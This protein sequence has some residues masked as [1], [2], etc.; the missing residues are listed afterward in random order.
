MEILIDGGS[1]VHDQKCG[2]RRKNEGVLWKK[3]SMINGEGTKVLFA[4]FGFSGR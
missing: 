1:I 3:M 2:V 4:F